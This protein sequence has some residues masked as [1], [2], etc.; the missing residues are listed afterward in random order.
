MPNP[1]SAPPLSFST[2]AQRT[3]EQPISFLITTAMA[4]PE[5]I[6]FAAGLVDPLTLPVEETRRIADTILSNSTRGRAAMQYDTTLGLSDLRRQVLKHL[7]ALEGKPA[8]AM[9]LTPGDILISTGSQQALYLVGEVLIDPGDIVIADNPSYFVFTGTLSSFGAKVMTVPMDEHGMDVNAVER[10]LTR[11]EADGKLPKVRVIYCTSYFQNPTGLTLS[12]DRRARLLDLA[13]RFS[14]GHRIL[15]LEDAAYRELRYE[16]PALPS[17]KSFDPD[18]RYTVL[19][20]TF[21]K[22]FAPGIKTGYTAM[23]SDLM[24]EV[25][26]QKG[27]HDFGSASLSQHIALEAMKSGAYAAQVANLCRSY[28][29]K[30]DMVLAALGR[31]MPKSPGISWTHPNGGFYVWLTLPDHVNTSRGAMFERAVEHGVLYVP[32]EY[33]FQPDESGF[34]PRNYIRLS[35]GQVAPEQIERGIERLAAVVSGQLGRGTGNA[36]VPATKHG[37]VARA[38]R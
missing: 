27:N 11:L 28:R 5:L 20:S 26:Q 7:E 37:R 22:P 18:N 17:I 4:N 9:S 10:L 13:R 29:A 19:A 33:C 3:K 23:P 2:K 24:H 16:G 8:S 6:N 14:H 1:P 36:P 15:I 35:F 12:L 21:S 25:L 34:I 32:G 38:T 30:R 31:Y